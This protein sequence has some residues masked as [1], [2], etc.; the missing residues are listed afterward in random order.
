MKIDELVKSPFLTTENTE[1]TEKFFL[2]QL[3]V[4]VN[5]VFSV[6]NS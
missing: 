6:V 4:S 3:V 5:S 1:T 2:L